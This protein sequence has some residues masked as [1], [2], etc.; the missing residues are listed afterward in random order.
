MKKYIYSLVT[1]LVCLSLAWSAGFNFD[2]RGPALFFTLG[3][4]L[5]LAS[6]AFIK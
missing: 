3:I 2:E 1:V 4:T 6:L 5:S